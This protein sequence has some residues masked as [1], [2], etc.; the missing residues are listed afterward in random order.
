MN[1]IVGLSIFG[2]VGTFG[3]KVIPPP[4]PNLRL[5][6][7][8]PQST[9]RNKKMTVTRFTYTQHS[10]VESVQEKRGANWVWV[11]VGE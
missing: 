5:L 11:G 4:P 8:I 2:N 3:N 6:A 1:G 10:H 7:K 9:Q